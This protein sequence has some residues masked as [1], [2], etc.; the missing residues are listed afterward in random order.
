MDDRTQAELTPYRVLG[1]LLAA[2]LSAPVPRFS[3][4]RKRLR[5][6]MRARLTEAFLE[7]RDRPGNGGSPGS[8]AVA[9]G[10]SS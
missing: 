10:L 4:R 6:A 5:A 2:E 1:A 3:R 9:S 7:E 8:A